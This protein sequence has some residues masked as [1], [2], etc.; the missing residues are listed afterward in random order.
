MD[1][2]NH[3]FI[4]AL[5]RWFTDS[6]FH[7]LNDSL[8]H[9]FIGSP[10]GWLMSLIHWVI[11][12]LLHWFIDAS[13]L[14]WF[15]DS[16]VHRLVGSLIHSFSCERIFS[17]YFIGISTT[18]SSFLDAP[19]HNFK[20]S[21]ILHLKY[22]KCIPLGRWFPTTMSCFETSAQAQTGHYL[23][24][25][26]WELIANASLKIMKRHVC[27]N[28]RDCKTL[29]RDGSAI[30]AAPDTKLLSTPKWIKFNYD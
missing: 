5:I 3:R 13:W 21:W 20:R 24:V 28:I 22:L 8:I 11:D 1:L 10:V 25:I 27:F 26:K 30:E 4:D 12:S 9:R 7:W 18:I 16:L 15:I 17:C 23:V 29:R 14:H 6:L 2:L 19:P